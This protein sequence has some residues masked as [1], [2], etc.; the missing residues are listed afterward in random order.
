MTDIVKNRYNT[1]RLLEKMPIIKTCDGVLI[2]SILY[3]NTWEGV[4]KAW[5][6]IYRKMINYNFNNKKI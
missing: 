4:R 1:T 3:D 2:G 5:S 6:G